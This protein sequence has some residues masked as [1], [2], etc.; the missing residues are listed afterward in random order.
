MKNLISITLALALITATVITLLSPAGAPDLADLAASGEVHDPH[1]GRDTGPKQTLAASGNRAA[2]GNLDRL[3]YAV[4][5]TAHMDFGPAVPTRTEHVEGVLELIASRRSPT[6]VLSAAR[7]RDAVATHSTDRAGARDAELE[8]NLGRTT[9][10]ELAPDG[11]LLRLGFDDGFVAGRRPWLAYLLSSLQ[12]AVRDG[13]SW[14]VDERD[15]T[16]VASVQYH[17]GAS[18]VLMRSKLTYYGDDVP[19]VIASAGRGCVAA[20]GFMT[21][22]A[23]SETLEYPIPGSNCRLRHGFE[24]SAELLANDPTAEVLAATDDPILIDVVE[25][26]KEGSAAAAALRDWRRQQVVGRSTTELLAAIATACR[27]PGPDSVECLRASLHLVWLLVE[28]PAAVADLALALDT[29]ALSD[30]AR[31]IALSALGAA[32]TQPAQDLLTMIAQDLGGPEMARYGAARSLA[33]VEAPSAT[34]IAAVKEL[35]HGGGAPASI[36]GVARLVAGGYVARLKGEAA[37]VLM[38]E[39]LACEPQHADAELIDWFEALGNSGDHRVLA[40][41]ERYL[42]SP[43]PEL[44]GLALTVLRKMTDPEM[45][46]VVLDRGRNDASSYVRGRALE[47]LAERREEARVR[48][49]LQHVATVDTD[50]SLRDRARRLL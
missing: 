27:D 8:R 41:A 39:L 37:D 17:R 43:E 13:A 7:M 45:M 5:A 3:R 21:S 30:Q 11:R 23:Y 46:A 4:K 2:V 15:A 36:R 42:G 19:S 48:A 50:A 12:F 18:G 34:T 29:N 24:F 31:A 16:G 9:W 44:R 10:V 35:V 49:F 28:S 26:A 40:V 47:L 33:L 6:A 14:T 38:R 32:G 1:V 22:A 25:A 20:Q